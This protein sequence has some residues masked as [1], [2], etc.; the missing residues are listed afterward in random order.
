MSF[1]SFLSILFTPIPDCFFL[2]PPFSL[3]L[4]PSH[5]F[6][7]PFFHHQSFYLFPFLCFLFSDLSL[8]ISLSLLSVFFLRHFPL[9]TSFVPFFSSF[10]SSY[11]YT[12][13]I[14]YLSLLLP[15]P[16]H[17]QEVY[18]DGL[19]ASWITRKASNY[20]ML[21]TISVSLI[22]KWAALR[23]CTEELKLG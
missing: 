18:V 5:S 2:Y 20:S 4:F 11:S 14:I 6:P 17:P 23:P 16:R 21:M 7:D 8:F 1:P 10:F 13:P 9:A 3:S 22:C 19:V 15:L 12:S